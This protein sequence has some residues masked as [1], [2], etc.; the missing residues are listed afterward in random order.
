[1]SLTV[2]PENPQRKGTALLKIVFMSI[3][4]RILANTLS[5]NK[6]LALKISADNPG[7]SMQFVARFVLASFLVFN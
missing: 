5:I 6:P 1:M 3:S 4:H 2:R 7:G